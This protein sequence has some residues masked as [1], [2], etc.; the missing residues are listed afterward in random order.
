MYP[1]HDLDRCENS[2]ISTVDLK[3]SK[4]KKEDDKYNLHNN[5]NHKRPTNN[6]PDKVNDTFK[7]QID[8]MAEYNCKF[9]CCNKNDIWVMFDTHLKLK[10]I[11]N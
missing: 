6:V 1:N 11:Q 9:A 5:Y 8:V 10:I 7:F 2:W 4:N 3:L